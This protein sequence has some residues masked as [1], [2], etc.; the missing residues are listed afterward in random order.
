MKPNVKMLYGCPLPKNGDEYIVGVSEKTP[1]HIS[2]TNVYKT[3]V[4]IDGSKNISELIKELVQCMNENKEVWDWL[5]NTIIMSLYLDI[6]KN[7]V[8]CEDV[9]KLCERKAD[10]VLKIIFG[11]YK[12]D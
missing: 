1:E 9:M 2:G 3:D 8:I 6:N 11:D 10:D 7:T 5:R 12:N 4:K